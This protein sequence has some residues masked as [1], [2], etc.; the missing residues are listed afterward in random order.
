M[1]LRVHPAL[2]TGII[3]ILDQSNSYCIQEHA[4][5]SVQND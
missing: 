1:Q 4:Q 2:D 5:F 3:D